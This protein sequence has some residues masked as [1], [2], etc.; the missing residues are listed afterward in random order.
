[1]ISY[2][3]LKEINALY[4]DEIKEAVNR[5]IDSGR[6]LFGDETHS[7]EKEYAQYTGTDHAIGCANGLDALTL[8]FRAYIEM[9]IMR[10][11]DEI[12]V[13]ANTYIASILAVSENR[14]IPV[15]VEP[16]PD[17]LQIDPTRIEEAITK[18][19]RGLMIV[20]LY[21]RCA[22]TEKI[23]EICRTFNLKLIED[24]AQAHGCFF[25]GRHTGALGD[26]AGH[27]FYPSKNLGALGDGGCVTTSDTE[28][29]CMVRTLAN[30]G[31]GIKYSFDYKGR[32]SRIDE[33]QAS[34]LRVKLRYLDRDNN[35]R[36]EIASL[37]LDGISNP[38]I[39]IPGRSGMQ[40]DHTE[41]YP[42]NV[43]HIFP[44]LTDYRDALKKYL[45]TRGVQTLIHYPVPPHRQKAYTEWTGRSYPIT[46]RIHSREL[47][48]PI[49]PILSPAE[50]NIVINLLNSFWN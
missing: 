5:V 46:E 19:T 28:L 16:D 37:Y 39:I 17:T 45:E 27:S 14:L 34:I 9:G 1:M 33:I 43:F 7:F 36:K 8:I 24:N 30:Y 41:G 3:D 2:L 20:H 10:P 4:S 31:S 12:I 49:S 22:Y 25:Q 18:R 47:S 40:H 13:P 35:H 42:S 6:Y 44:I 32:N 23:G 11:G 50:A 21:G 26:A 48:L 38:L 15:L 29:A